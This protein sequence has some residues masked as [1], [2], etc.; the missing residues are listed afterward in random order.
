MFDWNDQHVFVSHRKHNTVTKTTDGL[1][2]MCYNRPPTV[3]NL[4]CFSC[5]FVI[6]FSRILHPLNTA[7]YFQSVLRKQQ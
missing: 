1:G 3:I 4:L 2:C 6:D 7:S 5:A